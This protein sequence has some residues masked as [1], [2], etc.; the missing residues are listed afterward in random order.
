MTFDAEGKCIAMTGGYI[1]DR[2]VGNTDGLGG[3]YGLCSALELPTPTPAW[4]LRT[5]AQNWARLTGGE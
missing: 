2:R 1:M 3:V 5:P 4:L